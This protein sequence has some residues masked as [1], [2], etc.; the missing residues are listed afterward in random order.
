[1]T[2]PNTKQRPPLCGNNQVDQTI[3]IGTLPGLKYDL[4]E[5]TVK[6]AGSRVKIQF[7]NP[8]DMQHNLVIG[9]PGSV[10]RNWANG[11]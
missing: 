3:T 4:A 1:M 10:G 7:N 9:V 8:D 2:P 11:F 5:F 6:A